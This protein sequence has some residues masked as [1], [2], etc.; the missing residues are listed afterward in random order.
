MYLSPHEGV[1]G[2]SPIRLASSMNTLQH[3][4][5][6]HHT[7][8]GNMKQTFDEQMQHMQNHHAQ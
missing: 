6:E 8:L 7:V 5:L 4:V 3:H 1:R 2:I